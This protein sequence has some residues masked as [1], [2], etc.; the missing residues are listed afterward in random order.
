MP[1]AGASRHTAVSTKTLTCN[2]TTAPDA[3]ND[4]RRP[5]TVGSGKRRSRRRTL[6]LS[7]FVDRATKCL[8]TASAGQPAAKSQS[9]AELR[10]PRE[11]QGIGDGKRRQ[12]RRQHTH[13][14]FMMVSCVVKVFD[15]TMKSTDSRRTRLSTSVM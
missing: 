15:A 3:R 7:A 8:A 9:R 6:T 1:G 14:A 5:E 11:S 13:V 12:L 4:Q 10:A 2:G